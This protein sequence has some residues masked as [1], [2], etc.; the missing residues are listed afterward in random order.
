VLFA[1]G[2]SAQI[3]VSWLDPAKVRRITVVGDEKMAVYNDVAL[4][5][6]IRIYDKGVK[7]PATDTFGEFQ[8]SYRNGQITI[9]FIPWQEP[10]K[11]ECEHFLDCVR[12]GSRPLTDGQQGLAV[13]AVLEAADRSLR[14]GGMRVP[15]ELP[16]AG[17]RM[18]TAASVDGDGSAVAIDTLITLAE[19]EA[20]HQPVVEP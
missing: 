10:L 5:E 3:H 11:I 12:T 19:P 1:G 7:P 17:W 6:K 8:M 18:P 14:D 20:L 2:L 9:P 13:V 16:K 15:V 4:V